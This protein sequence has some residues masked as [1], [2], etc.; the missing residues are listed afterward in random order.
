MLAHDGRQTAPARL[1][2]RQ[3]VGGEEL[4]FFSI[5]VA[6]GPLTSQ[7][8]EIRLGDTILLATKPVGTLILDGLLP[9]KHLYLLSAGTGG[10]PLA[11]IVRTGNL[12]E[13]GQGHPDPHHAPGRR[14]ANTRT[15]WSST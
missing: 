1:F 14:A 11:S 12:R 13:V 10:A 6:G 8:E 4:E 9:G 2:D 15:S 3:P 5:K 7:F